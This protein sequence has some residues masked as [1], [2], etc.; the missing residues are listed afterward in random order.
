MT[1]DELR[2]RTDPAA[3]NDRNFVQQVQAGARRDFRSRVLGTLRMAAAV[4]GLIS[5][6]LLGTGGL[7]VVGALLS[8]YVP[9]VSVPPS[10]LFTGAFLGVFGAVMAGVTFWIWPGSTGLLTSGVAA[11][12]RVIQVLDIRHGLSIKG[13]GVRATLMTVKVELEVTPP[14]GAPYRVT[15]SERILQTD[16]ASLQ[17]G[18]TVAVRVSPSN[19]QRLLFDWNAG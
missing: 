17:V 8:P 14:G 9:G 2:L 12:A 5:L 19:P 11:R 10:A 4:T 7:L 18:D 3:R 1:P 13:T 6:A 16:I 15:H